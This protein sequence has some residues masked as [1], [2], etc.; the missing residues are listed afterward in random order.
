M[1]PISEKDVT[2]LFTLAKIPVLR[3]YQLA[4][5][6]FSFQLGED[7]KTTQQNALYRAT[8]PSWLVKTPFGLI[9]LNLRKRV[10]EIDWSDTPYRAVQLPAT[11]VPENRDPDSITKD[12][13]TKS[14]VIVHAY[15]L[16]KA[17]EYL[18]AL[19]D[20]LKNLTYDAVQDA[21][22]AQLPGGATVKNCI[23]YN[24]NHT[25]EDVIRAIQA[26]AQPKAT[27]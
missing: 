9:A 6:Y 25:K 16:I 18:S 10:V 21:L 3:I 8:R 13:V 7:E 19:G 11:A 23:D 22:D 1:N 15:D 14:S 12:G 2:S 20:H 5:S 27:A 4:H 17:A 24:H 26:A